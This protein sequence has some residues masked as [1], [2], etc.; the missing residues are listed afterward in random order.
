MSVC[1]I[2]E[3]MYSWRVPGE[4]KAWQTSLGRAHWPGGAWHEVLFSV[5]LLPMAQFSLKA[6]WSRRVEFSD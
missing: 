3:R 1:S 2:F 6:P 5:I 4:K